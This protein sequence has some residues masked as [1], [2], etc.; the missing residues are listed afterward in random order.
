M[1]FISKPMKSILVIAL[2][3]ICFSVDAQE[4]II[5]FHNLKHTEDYGYMLNYL[6]QT[7]DQKKMDAAMEKELD[8]YRVK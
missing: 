8:S 4:K 2:C 6:A 5:E 1:L 7:N 3:F